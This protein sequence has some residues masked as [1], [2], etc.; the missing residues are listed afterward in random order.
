MFGSTSVKPASAILSM[1]LPDLLPR[2]PIALR[3]K[4]PT[5][6]LIVNSPLLCNISCVK[7]QVRTKAMKMGF[8][9]SM[10]MVPHPIAMEL[11]FSPDLVV[12]RMPGRMARMI[13]PAHSRMSIGRLVILYSFFVQS[14]L[15]FGRLAA[16]MRHAAVALC[17]CRDVGYKLYIFLKIG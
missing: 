2:N 16:Y 12:S 11:T 14:S 5:G 10:P 9:H 3:G 15:R 7:R 4:F 17:G 8:S 6:T 13:S 1:S